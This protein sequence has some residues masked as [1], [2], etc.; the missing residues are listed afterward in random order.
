VA[1][2]T[3]KA[4]VGI[5]LLGSLGLIVLG[6]LYVSGLRTEERT[7]F[8]IVF[9]ESVSG[10]SN[11]SPVQYLGVPV[12]NVT[13]IRVTAANRVQ[14]AISVSD[15]R[16]TLRAGTK[17]TLVNFNLA[18]GTMA[19][20]LADGDP[21]GV[22]L[23]P[24]SVIPTS[25]SLFAALG[26]QISNFVEEFNEIA[27]AVKVGLQGMEEGQLVR[28]VENFDA[29]LVEARD[30]VSN[31]NDT[32]VG[33]QEDIKSGIANFNSLSEEF[34]TL[35]TDMHDLATNLNDLTVVVKEK[36]EPMQPAETEQK[37]QRVLDN[38]AELTE[39][40]KTTA[41]VIDTVSTSMLHETQNVQYMLRSVIE[42]VSETFES[43]RQV[44]GE[45]Q[46][47]PSS[48]LRGRAP[49]E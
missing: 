24:G 13:D 39:R 25:E 26:T 47:D 22:P 30:F 10:L 1:T 3:Q 16:V 8:F 19:I 23:P 15:R 28:V 36:I 41:E 38:L 17:A 14:V 7:E 21:E 31:A 42:T 33:V 43:I 32:L 18:A 6:G 35:S 40:L 37:A 46:R 44:A 49:R 27:A 11:G 48:L 5:F 20:S 29:T 45:L 34:K 12:G 9:D 2:R 4:K